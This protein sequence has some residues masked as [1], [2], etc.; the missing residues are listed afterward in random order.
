MQLL[1]R[2]QGHGRGEHFSE[3][4]PASG[5]RFYPAQTALEIHDIVFQGCLSYIFWDFHPLV[6]WTFIY[7]FSHRVRAPY[8]MHSPTRSFPDKNNPL[9]SSLRLIH[10]IYIVRSHDKRPLFRLLSVALNNAMYCKIRNLRKILNT[11]FSTIELVTNQICY[12]PTEN[13]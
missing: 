10:L 7:Y 5:R 2:T 6:L 11:S 3:L 8:I 13:A 9:L 4:V 1:I 12:T